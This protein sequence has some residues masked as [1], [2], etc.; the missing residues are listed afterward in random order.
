MNKNLK[1][2]AGIGVAV[3]IGVGG[4]A[5]TAAPASAQAIKSKGTATRA[6]SNKIHRGVDKQACLSIKEVQHIVGTKGKYT[7]YGDGITERDFKGA[8]GSSVRSVYVFF[9]HGCAFQAGTELTRGR[10][11]DTYNERQYPNSYI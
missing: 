11:Q 5:A 2:L 1:R 7:N 6:E 4:V 9:N 10:S 3:A 8:K